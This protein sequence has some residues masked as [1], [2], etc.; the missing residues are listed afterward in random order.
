[1]KVQNTLKRSRIQNADY[2]LSTVCLAEGGA[3]GKYR[4]MR[5]REEEWEGKNCEQQKKERVCW[6]T[7]Y[8]SGGNRFGGCKIKGC[9]A[10]LTQCLLA[11]LRACL[12]ACLSHQMV[13]KGI[14]IWQAYV[15]V[16]NPN[17]F[18]IW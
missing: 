10:I 11:Y 15:V 12:I 3:I 17:Y 13:N 8:S 1:M 5:R 7:T 4:T 2:H 18:Y 9:V 16:S 6:N 14:S